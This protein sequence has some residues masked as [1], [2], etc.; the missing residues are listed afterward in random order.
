MYGAELSGELVLLTAAVLLSTTGDDDPSRVD[1]VGIGF[2][3]EMG[4][5]EALVS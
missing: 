5:D 2:P 1:K 3:E 4:L